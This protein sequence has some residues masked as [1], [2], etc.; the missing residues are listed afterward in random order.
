MISKRIWLALPLL[1]LLS[2]GVVAESIELRVDRMERT[3]NSKSLLEMMERLDALQQEVQRLRGQLEEQGHKLEGMTGR[4]RELYLDMDRRL[5]RLE[6][7]GGA[8]RVTGASK[9]EPLTSATAPVELVTAET[10]ETQVET[11]PALSTADNARERETYQKAFDLL[12]ELRYEQA[13]VAF[14]E[15]LTAYP[16]GRY[17]HIAQ[18]WLG[19]A[20]YA[21]R[22][23]EQAIKDYQTLLDK[24]AKSPKRAEAMLKI[25]YSLSELKKPDEAKKSLQQL[26][27]T[28]PDSTEAGQAKKQLKRLK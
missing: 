18:Y 10:T 19:E 20:A 2:G 6:R 8:K 24:Y 7:E 22:D 14:R 16:E 13:T 25:G 3:L 17:A 9:S 4:Q 1:G 28:F 23:F 26:I 15:F 5:S 21:R 27:D 12:R 11:A